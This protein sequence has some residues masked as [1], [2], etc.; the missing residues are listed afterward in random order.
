M[1]KSD[2]T[3]T[4]SRYTITDISIETEKAVVLEILQSE[5]N[6]RL[7]EFILSLETQLYFDTEISYIKEVFHCWDDAK[8]VLDIGCGIGDYTAML[9]ES[10]PEK[11]SQG[12]EQN[13][14][15][16][17]I[18]SKK[19]KLKNLS[20]ECADSHVLNAQ[21]MHRYD[22]VFMRAVLQHLDNR[23]IVI[24]N[25]REYLKPNG[26]VIIIESADYLRSSSMISQYIDDLFEKINGHCTQH[27]INRTASLELMKSIVL[28]KSEPSKYFEI[29]SSNISNEGKTEKEAEKKLYLS[30]NKGNK[31]LLFSQ[32]LTFFSLWKKHYSLEVDLGKVYDEYKTFLAQENA[33]LYEGFHMLCLKKC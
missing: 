2:Q 6:Q 19:H 22:I 9:A 17:E 18:A 24:R 8:T 3:F 33:Y 15:H 4:A 32:K 26:R 29:E 21:L 20:F 23:D 7:W 13:P 14:E 11:E 16:F 5:S 12:I 1:Q 27:K 25:I 30:I 28:K 31:S 10:F